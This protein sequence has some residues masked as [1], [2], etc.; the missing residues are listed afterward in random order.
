MSIHSTAVVD[1]GAVLDESVEVGPYAVIDKGVTIGSGCS[2]GPHVVIT[3]KT[4]LGSDNSVG[5][6]AVL[7]TPPQDFK[8]Q[9]DETELIIG[10]NNQIRE[11]VSIHRGTM[12]GHGRTV[13]GSDVMLMAHAHVG[14][15]CIL[16]EGV[17]IGNGTNLAGHMEIGTKATVSG[18]TGTHQFARVGEYAFV[19]GLSTIGKDIP[20]YVIAAGIRNQCHLAGLNR[21]GLRRAGFDTETL[22]ILQQVYK[23]LFRSPELLL[24]DALAKV[25]EQFFHCKAVQKILN[26]FATS[27]RGV[28]RKGDEHSK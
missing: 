26:F 13:I 17:V 25:E 3:G 28:L 11:Y 22:R 12:D 1:P 6:F 14:H 2:I 19:G 20:P 23:I 5:P 15:D 7:G 8:Y 9:D 10:N 21:V 4:T 18:M 27:S 24:G 16:E